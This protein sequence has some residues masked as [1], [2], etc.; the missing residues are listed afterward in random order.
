[1]RHRKLK[2]LAYRLMVCDIPPLAATAVLT[3]VSAD[4][5]DDAAVVLSTSICLSFTALFPC[6]L[7]VA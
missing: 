5:G 2:G 1:M 6:F 7:A 4:D 3:F